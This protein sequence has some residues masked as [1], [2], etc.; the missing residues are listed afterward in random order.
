MG[1][2]ELV[3]GTGYT[4]DS[5]NGWIHIPAVIGDVVIT[6]N[7]EPIPAVTYMIKASEL[8]G[9]T[10]DIPEGGLSV[11]ENSECTIKLTAKPGYLIKKTDVIIKTDKTLQEGEDYTYTEAAD[12]K[13]GTVKIHAVTADMELFVYADP[14]P[15]SFYDHR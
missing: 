9:A 5:S 11:K 7:A 6:A 13:S 1:G 3:A 4:Y 10:S 8:I 15:N 14:E 2:T 12:Y